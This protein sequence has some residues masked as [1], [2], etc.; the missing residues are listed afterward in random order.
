M[1]EPLPPRICPFCGMPSSVPHESQARCIEALKAEIELTR[2]LL[3]RGSGA[4][5]APP[6][7]SK[8]AQSS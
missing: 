6:R 3:Q 5:D 2:R 1:P 8:D 7:P 4:T